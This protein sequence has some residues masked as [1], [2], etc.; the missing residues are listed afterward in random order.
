MRDPSPPSR[1]INRRSVSELASI[2]VDGEYEYTLES[3]SSWEDHEKGIDAI[4]STIKIG[5]HAIVAV[6]RPIINSITKNTE[7]DANSKARWTGET[8]EPNLSSRRSCLNLQMIEIAAME[9]YDEKYE[10]RRYEMRK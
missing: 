2:S 6:T 7:D 1:L 8:A 5:R 10:A 3:T 9:R 4:L